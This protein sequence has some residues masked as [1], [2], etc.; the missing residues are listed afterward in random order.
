MRV[1]LYLDGFHDY[2]LVVMFH[3][4]E[5]FGICKINFVSC[6]FHV[7]EKR[8]SFFFFFDGILVF[9]DT[10]I[11][12]SVCLSNVRGW[13]DFA[14][15]FIDPLVFQLDFIFGVSEDIGYFLVGA[16]GCFDIVFM[17]DFANFI[18]SALDIRKEGI[19][20]QKLAGKLLCV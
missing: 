13:A 4:K 6:F 3:V 17:E 20:R 16:K 11:Y 9:C 1:F 14:G 15:N 2:S 7:L 18:C 19:Y 8:G 12:S 10:C 5:Q